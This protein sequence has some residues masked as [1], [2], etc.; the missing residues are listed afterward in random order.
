M[1]RLTEDF[2]TGMVWAFHKAL[3]K[4]RDVKPHLY[5]HPLR[6]VVINNRLK[7]ALGRAN[8]RGRIEI[9]GFFVGLEK[10]EDNLDQL[11][12][13]ITHELAH[14]YVGI[15]EGHNEKWQRMA[16]YVGAKP[17]RVAKVNEDIV[18][19]TQPPW[20]LVATLSSGKTVRC[21]TAYKRTFNYLDRPRAYSINGETVQR[22]EWVRLSGKVA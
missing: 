3:D 14:L 4:E 9:A 2:I 16:R 18:K 15:Q 13:T 22:F 8:I 12:D 19:A 11:F 7:R 5:K 1:E 17:E 20:L 10:T 6:T 21:K